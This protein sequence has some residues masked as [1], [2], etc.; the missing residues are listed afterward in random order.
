MMDPYRRAMAKR[1]LERE[2]ILRRIEAQAQRVRIE[3]DALLRQ[4]NEGRKGTQ[5][6]AAT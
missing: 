2:D 1:D 6:G 5:N 3:V 4:I